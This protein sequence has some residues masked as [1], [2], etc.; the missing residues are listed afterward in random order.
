[1]ITA[2]LLNATD[3]DNSNSELLYS[4]LN[5][6]N[7]SYGYVARL[8]APNIPITS[9]TQEDIDLGRIIYVHNGNSGEDKIAL[10]VNRVIN[11]LLCRKLEH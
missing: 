11:F 7:N 3:S 9:F 8:E 4:V 6:S 2:D 10:Q 5:Q 1:M